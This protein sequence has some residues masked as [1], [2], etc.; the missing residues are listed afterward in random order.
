MSIT[1]DI[2]GF[3]FLANHMIRDHKANPYSYL[4]DII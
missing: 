2:F 1:L 3:I 4:H